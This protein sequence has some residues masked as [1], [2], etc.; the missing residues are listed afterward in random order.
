LKILEVQ[1]IG[2]SGK[3][4]LIFDHALGFL[5]TYARGAAFHHEPPQLERDIEWT[6]GE[7]FRPDNAG[8]LCCPKQ[9]TSRIFTGEKFKAGLGQWE[10]KE[11]KYYFGV[12]LPGR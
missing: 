9:R 3:G 11:I 1:R 5:G 4:L 8:I 10:V 6:A 2:L 12:R 7:D